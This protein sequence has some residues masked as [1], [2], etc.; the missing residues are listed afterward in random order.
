M[1]IIGINHYKIDA[2][3]RERK[4]KYIQAQ[5]LFKTNTSNNETIFQ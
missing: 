3:N 4:T 2:L 5:Q 1:T